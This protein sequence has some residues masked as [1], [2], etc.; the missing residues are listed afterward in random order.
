M[1]IAREAADLD[2]SDIDYIAGHGNSMCDYDAAESRAI[3]NVFGKRWNIPISSFKSMCGQALA[4]SSAMQVVAACLS[5]RDQIIAP[6]TNYHQIDP[7]CDLDYVPNRAR[8]S[9]IRSAM[10]L[11]R[12][13]GGS[14][15][16]MILAG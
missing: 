16:A 7:T 10:L 8:R 15:T 9:R 5:L 11:A 1:S 12:G 2:L 3:K 4:A 13:L 6:T 14:H